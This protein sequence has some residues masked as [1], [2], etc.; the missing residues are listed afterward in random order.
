MAKGLAKL[1]PDKMSLGGQ[2]GGFKIEKPEGKGVG[3]VQWEMWAL[4]IPKKDC[5]TIGLQVSDLPLALI[6]LQ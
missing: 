6:R 4:Y 1:E 5:N 3:E 2:D